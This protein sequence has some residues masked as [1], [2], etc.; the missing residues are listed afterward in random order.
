MFFFLNL[1]TNKMCQFIVYFTISQNRLQ[2]ALDELNH[3]D[4]N[5]YQSSQSEKI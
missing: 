3:L 4:E 5:M 2:K 1:P